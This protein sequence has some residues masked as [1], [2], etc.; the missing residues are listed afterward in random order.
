MKENDQEYLEKLLEISSLLTFYFLLVLRI[1][2]N[3]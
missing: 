3:Y 1:N 2:N